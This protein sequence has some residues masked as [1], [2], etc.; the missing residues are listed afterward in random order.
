MFQKLSKIIGI[1][2]FG[3]LQ[4]F[5]NIFFLQWSRAEEDVT[6]NSMIV[7]EINKGNIEWCIISLQMFGKEV[8]S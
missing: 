1:D 8:I 4:E 7:H 6:Q 2:R 3:L 5:D